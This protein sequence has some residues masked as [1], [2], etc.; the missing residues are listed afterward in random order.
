[1]SAHRP[2][3]RRCIM[4][5]PLSHSLLEAR[6]F[7]LR[8]APVWSPDMPGQVFPRGLLPIPQCLRL[9]RAAFCRPPQCLRLT[10]ADCDRPTQ[11]LRVTR[12]PCGRPMQCLRVTCLPCGR[13]TLCFRVTSAPCGLPAQCLRLTC[14]PCGLPAQ[15][16]RLTRATWAYSESKPAACPRDACGRRAQHQRHARVILPAFR[17]DV[18]APPRLSSRPARGPLP[19]SH[20]VRH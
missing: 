9:S 10:R 4:L 13:S 8:R 20:P 14:A 5:R 16:L 19:F 3:L 2:G 18:P 7:R 1:M 11:C 6:V 17:R 12:P 15:C